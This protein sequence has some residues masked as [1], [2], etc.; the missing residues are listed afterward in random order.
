MSALQGLQLVT[1]MLVA[2][3][4]NGKVEPPTASADRS[5][6]RFRFDGKADVS[7]VGGE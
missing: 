1:R 6:Q 2:D 5:V 3:V 7:P 4:V